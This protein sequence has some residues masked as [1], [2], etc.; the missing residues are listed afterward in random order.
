[1]GERVPPSSS[2][3]FFFFFF[4]CH[5][6]LPFFLFSASPRLSDLFFS[7]LSRDDDDRQEE[8]NGC[9]SVLFY[10]VIFSFCFF[11]ATFSLLP[12]PSTTRSR[13]LFILAACLCTLS[14]AP[15]PSRRRSPHSS[16]GASR[17]R[18]IS[19]S[20]PA[21]ARGSRTSIVY[22]ANITNKKKRTNQ[23]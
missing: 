13:C 21:T 4:M 16:R 18:N 19:P 10:I 17:D 2:Q 12:L 1:M 3:A 20:H 11:L 9:P 14:R 8:E 6:R 15:Q 23:L 7:V 22:W 5:L